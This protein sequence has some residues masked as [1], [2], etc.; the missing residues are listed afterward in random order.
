MSHCPPAIPDFRKA[1][2]QWT[3]ARQRRGARERGSREITPGFPT[4]T[5]H[6]SP[7]ASWPAAPESLR[8][9]LIEPA[10]LPTGE[11]PAPSTYHL[12]LLTLSW[13]SVTTSLGSGAY[14]SVAAICWASAVVYHTR[15]ALSALALAASFIFGRISSQVNDEIG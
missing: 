12:R 15:N 9:V 10:P 4:L 5:Y 8:V 6:L 1:E 11:S 7:G 13:T 2:E 14:L 3:A